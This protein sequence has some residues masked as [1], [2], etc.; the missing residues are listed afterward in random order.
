MYQ[1]DALMHCIS[2]EQRTHHSNVDD[3]LP[4]SHDTSLN[5]SFTNSTEGTAS[6]PLNCDGSNG[7]PPTVNTYTSH[8]KLALYLL[9]GSPFCRN[10]ECMQTIY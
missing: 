10:L 9:T 2:F 3:D 7:S 5:S 6:P 4:R 1:S 8:S